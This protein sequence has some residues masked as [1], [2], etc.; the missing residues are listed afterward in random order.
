MAYGPEDKI[1]HSTLGS[2]QLGIHRATMSGH[3]G[4]YSKLIAARTELQSMP[5]KKSGHNK[6]AG[7]D[8]FELGDF[9][10]AIQNLFAKYGLVDIIQFS[11]DMA[12]MHLVDTADGSSVMFTS[13]MADAQ[14]KGCHPIQNLG[15]VETY[16]RRYL[17]VTAMAIVEHDAL[18][19]V[20]GSPNGSPAP[21]PKPAPRAEKPVESTADQ[22]LFVD[23]LIELGKASASLAELQN[24]WKMNQA[25][26]DG[27]K[28]GNPALFQKLQ[29]EFATIKAK[30]PKE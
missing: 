17:Y 18:E 14:L 28:K 30:F 4:V 27:V 19:S 8:Y 21:A 9:L 22:T 6:F 7:Y 23:G 11:K 20:T 16:Q 24:L 3:G 25:Q 12:V 15:A 13:P 2:G 5:I 26:V 29:N 1:A 10:P